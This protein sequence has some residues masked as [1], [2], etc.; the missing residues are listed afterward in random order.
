MTQTFGPWYQFLLL[1]LGGAVGRLLAALLKLERRREIFLWVTFGSLICW[2]FV[3][4]LSSVLDSKYSYMNSSR[5]MKLITCICMGAVPPVCWLIKTSADD[6]KVA[7][8][9]LI[10][11]G[12][13][14]VVF[15]LSTLAFDGHAA[16]W[17]LAALAGVIIGA[18]V[19]FRFVEKRKDISIEKR[20]LMQ[21]TS[22]SAIPTIIFI[23][24]LLSYW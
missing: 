20:F 6:A 22:A 19:A 3:F 12:L 21:C 1:F 15:Q 2:E 14:I 24:W 7:L 4:L 5:F 10:G 11:S 17:G 18:V 16:E 8:S 23:S 13:G 9:A